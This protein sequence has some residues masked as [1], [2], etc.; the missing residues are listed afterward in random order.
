MNTM[1]LISCPACASA[2]I[3]PLSTESFGESHQLVDRR[4]PDCEHRDRVVVSTVASVMWERAQ[5]R[6]A[7]E[8]AT[9]LLVLE[10]TAWLGSRA[11]VTREA[12]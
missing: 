4:C 5:Q 10:L 12:P 3:Y 8:L 7:I 2:L 6:R 11:D 1:P 9:E